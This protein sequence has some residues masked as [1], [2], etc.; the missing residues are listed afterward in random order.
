MARTTKHKL[1]WTPKGFGRVEDTGCYPDVVVFSI[2]EA[3]GIEGRNEPEDDVWALKQRLETAGTAYRAS[4]HNQEKPVPR[5]VKAYMRDIA[6]RSAE[7]CRL[8]ENPDSISWG[9]LWRAEA[10]LQ[11]EGIL[12]PGSQLEKMGI[13]TVS[14]G[15][16]GRETFLLEYAD[17]PKLLRYVELLANQSLVELN[18][19]QPGRTSDRPLY[20][21]VHAMVRYWEDTLGREF[22]VSYHQNAPTSPVGTFLEACLKPL[23]EGALDGLVT[24]MR[25]LLTDRRNPD[26]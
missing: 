24:Q 5:E 19:G 25:N 4:K 9:H 20:V 26:L 6:K 21:W 16:N 11:Q 7:L 15:E 22:T 17:A 12:T 23:D 3:F 18:E 8:L 2:A 10:H 14:E 13:A 1:G